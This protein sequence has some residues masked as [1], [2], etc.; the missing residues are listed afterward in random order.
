MGPEY[1]AKCRVQGTQGI[2][3]V[4]LNVSLLVYSYSMIL[5]RTSD[6]KALKERT[7]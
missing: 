6:L 5:E 4:I 3:F 7:A 2:F 1:H